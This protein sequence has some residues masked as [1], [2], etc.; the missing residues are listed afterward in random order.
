MTGQYSLD[1]VHVHLNLQQQTEHVY[2][3]AYA[4]MVTEDFALSDST[5]PMSAIQGMIS[6]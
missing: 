4:E 1:H 3:H 2:E 5:E 6:G